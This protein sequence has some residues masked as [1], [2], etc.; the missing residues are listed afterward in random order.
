[1]YEYTG[2]KCIVCKQRF[3]KGDDIV[4]CPDCGTPYHRICYNK[5]GKCIN[6][7]LHEKGGTWRPDNVSE[8]I[9]ICPRCHAPNPAATMY[10]GQC[11]MPLMQAP[12]GM[13]P[14]GQERYPRQDRPYGRTDGHGGFDENGSLGGASFMINYSDPLCGFNPNEQYDNNVAL[15]EL[16]AYVDSNTH[17][18]L[19]R[20]KIMK[21]TKLSFSWNLVAM[22]FPEL[23]FAN[24]KL[25]IPAIL[26]VL[27][28]VVTIVPNLL[29]MLYSNNMRNGF[30]GEI[31]AHFDIAGS[32]FQTLVM[33]TYILHMSFV[34]LMAVFANRIY[35]DH[36]LREIPRIK[37][38]TAP[39]IILPELHRRGGT[40]AG[41]LVVFICID[42]GLLI[43]Y[44]MSMLSGMGL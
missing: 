23:F 9:K 27:V 1:M 25:P 15:A 8:R 7:A 29:D 22:L 14:A 3:E 44:Y 13:P 12:G 31:L 41:L 34:F 18:Y 36:C 37:K 32:A 17:Y 43:V 16:G 19:P 4:V 11:G 39:N 38:K 2:S 20:F 33:L 21:E 40:S 42:V 24:R 5:E 30:V 35:Y 6:T 28:R 26:S 10:C